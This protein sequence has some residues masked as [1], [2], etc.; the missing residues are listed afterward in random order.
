MAQNEPCS[1]S[2]APAQSIASRSR[3]LIR[4]PILVLPELRFLLLSH[5]KSIVDEDQFEDEDTKG[6]GEDRRT[7]LAS[8]ARSSSEMY[9]AVTREAWFLMHDFATWTCS[10]AGSR[11]RVRNLVSILPSPASAP[12]SSNSPDDDVRALQQ[13]VQLFLIPHIQQRRRTIFFPL[14][15][16]LRTLQ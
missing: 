15:Q 1:P 7:N 6:G 4:D 16:V 5:C 2:L 10:G 3:G 13:L 9:E 14:N 8:R 12:S 11:L